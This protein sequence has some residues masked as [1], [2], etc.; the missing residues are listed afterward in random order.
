MPLQAN[1]FTA[2]K[3]PLKYFEAAAVGTVSVAAPTVNHLACIN[4]GI[5]GRIARAHEWEQQID[6]VLASPQAYRA[7]AENAHADVIH[8]H[9]WTQQLPRLLQALGWR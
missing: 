1:V 4:D 3:S 7:M 6:A 2:C 9:A 8:H 5:N